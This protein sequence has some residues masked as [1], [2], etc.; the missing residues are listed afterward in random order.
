MAEDNYVS[1]LGAAFVR[2]EGTTV[3][4]RSAVE[5][6]E[7]DRDTRRGNQLRIWSAG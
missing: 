3:K 2:S 6:E 7:I 4:D 5:M 1:A